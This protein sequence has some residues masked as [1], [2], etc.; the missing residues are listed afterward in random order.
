MFKHKE[1]F[2]LIELLVVLFLFSLIVL[3]SFGRLTF[4]DS[5]RLTQETERLFMVFSYLG[6]KAIASQQTQS[7]FLDER[8]NSYRYRANS[9]KF[10]HY[11][12]GKS[13]SFGFL[14]NAFGPPANPETAITK[15]I[16]FQS[17]NN[18]HVVYFYSQGTAS[19]GTVYLVDRNK[20]FMK[21]L[22][23]SVAGVAYTRKYHYT[24]N[25]WKYF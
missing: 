25:G 17:Q 11:T 6:Q 2:S 4:L 10:R 19:S 12:L 24:Q 22:T 20:R 1:C 7:L 3:F 5:Y 9:E 14:D 18:E 8:S 16:T 23:C 21:A 13:V 15:S